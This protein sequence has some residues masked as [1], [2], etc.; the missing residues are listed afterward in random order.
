M[1]AY[2]YKCVSVCAYVVIDYTTD[3]MQ[4]GG[5]SIHS[6]IGISSNAWSMQQHLWQKNEN[7]TVNSKIP[8]IFKIQVL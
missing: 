8:S 3:N 4:I 5:P 6:S 7:V 1:N 2:A